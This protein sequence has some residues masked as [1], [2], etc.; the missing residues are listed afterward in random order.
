[1]SAKQATSE[2]HYTGNTGWLRAAVLG[3]NDGILS[4]AG[5]ILG[6]AAAHPARASILIAGVS[7]L[8]SGAMSMAA[9]EY[10]SVSSQADTEQADLGRERR[11]LQ[12]NA[13]AEHAELAKIYVGR[14]LDPAL[15]RQVADQL[16][17]HDAIGAHARDEL[18][19]SDTLAARPIQAAL[20]SAASF[21]RRCRL[22]AAG[23]RAHAGPL[24]DPGGRGGLA[25]VPGAAGRGRGE[26][27]RCQHLEGRAP[28]HLLGSAG[29]GSHLRHRRLVRRGREVINGTPAPIS[30]SRM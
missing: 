29:D 28:R 16:M 23:R 5:L 25:G 4:T 3:A 14:G 13:K 8:V 26:N 7:G 2:R 11:E 18:G 27:R 21:V 12:T 30:A 17:A 15:A 9:G 6:V 1:M 20:A 10:V 22:A 19:I 24:A